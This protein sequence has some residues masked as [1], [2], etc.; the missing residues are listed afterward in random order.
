M[1]ICTFVNSY[2]LAQA[3][4]TTT[5]LLILQIKN[6]KL[7]F[8]NVRLHLSDAGIATTIGSAFFIDMNWMSPH[9]ANSQIIVAWVGRV[10]CVD[11]YLHN[12]LRLQMYSTDAYFH[13][14][15]SAQYKQ[16]VSEVYCKN[17]GWKKSWFF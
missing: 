12:V 16:Q 13:C 17:Q 2:V 7:T 4:H 14:Q 10:P 9:L 6:K 3:V 8:K 5:P 1:L 11:H 15:L